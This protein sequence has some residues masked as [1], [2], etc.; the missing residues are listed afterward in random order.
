M[1]KEN[2]LI[3]RDIS[4]LSFN[5][6]VLQEANDLTVPLIQRIHFLGIFS[7][8]MDEFF[9][10][11]VAALRRM[12][13]L[14]GKNTNFHFEINPQKIL[15]E[16]Q[17]IV[18]HQQNEFDRIWNSIQRD[19]AKE[20]VFLVDETNLTPVQQDF[21]RKYFE[22]EVESNII[23][24][25]IENIPTFPY[26][27]EKSLYLGVVMSKSDAAYSQK[28]AIIEVPSRTVGRF[29]ELPTEDPNVHQII[30]LEDVIKYNLPHIFSYFGFD[31]FDA[32]VFKVTKD[33]E[34]DIDNDISTSLVQKIEKGI[35]SRRKGKTVR[36]VYDKAM[37]PILLEYILTRL[38]VSRKDNI[39]PGGT[40]HNFRHFME[41]PDVFPHS[42]TSIIQP[43]FVHPKLAGRLRV[44]DII[45][46]DDVLLSFPYHSFVSIIDLLREAAINAIS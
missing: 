28:F 34:F 25:L 12:V 23:P 17:Q 16:I 36:F 31:R 24:L 27:R 1:K 26:L 5:A 40:I 7:N 33:A 14:K 44:T 13:E 43:S 45:L 8:N 3:P 46:K 4:W 11:R 19:M 32:H 20:N 15:D 10:V 30:L 37:N 6:R 21:V 29:K 22:K 35:K 41:F 42:E 39:I 2:T 18:L 9:R 38:N